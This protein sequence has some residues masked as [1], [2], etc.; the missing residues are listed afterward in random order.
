[1]DIECPICGG[2][3]EYDSLQD[4]EFDGSRYNAVWNGKC[5]C[6]GSGV[7][8]TEVYTFSYVERVEVEEE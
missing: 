4:S 5:T 3:V 2:E 7:V 6:C 8:W 1:M